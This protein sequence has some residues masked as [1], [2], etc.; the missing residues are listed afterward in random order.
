MST[1][2]S[3]PSDTPGV[4][5]LPPLIY[6]GLFAV[7]YV[8]HRA[9]PLRLWGGNGVA[10]LARLAGWALVGAGVLLA[11][12]AAWL[13]RRAGTTPN[14]TRPTTALVLSGPYRFTRNPM[15]VALGLC[16]LG[17]TLL[18]NTAWPLVLFP[19]LIILVQRWVIVPEEAYLERKFGA[20]YRVY[21]DRVRRWL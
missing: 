3:P 14:P 10:A 1:S 15:Y 20:E 11:A 9:V 12:S 17:A 21:C 5:V 19:A 6:A 13:F 16:Y 2:S 7:A 8:L 4:R 18:V